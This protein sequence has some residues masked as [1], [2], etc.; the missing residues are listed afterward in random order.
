VA[1][2]PVVIGGEG[3]QS[4][5]PYSLVV[6]STPVTV[7][8]GLASAGGTFSKRLLL[9]SGIAPGVHTI[10]LSAIGSDGSALSLTQTFTV[11]PN[12]T[13]SA[14]GEVS[15]Q[16]TAGLAVTGVDGSMATSAVTLATLLVLMGMLMMVARRRAEGAN[17]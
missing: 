7:D 5:S 15:G 10:T 6:R 16:R 9:P 11:A 1:G 17:T 8:S 4:G 13:F 14:I 12:G 2:A 3:L